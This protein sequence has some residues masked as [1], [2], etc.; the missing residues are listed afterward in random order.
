MDINVQ[1][2]AD[3]RSNNEPHKLLDIREVHE[4]AICSIEGSL[5]IPMNTI[6]ENLDKHPKD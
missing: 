1:Q 3:M 5:D 4:V 2:L 6:D